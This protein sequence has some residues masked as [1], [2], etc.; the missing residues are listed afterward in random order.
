MYFAI[1]LI[2]FRLVK[3]LFRS[4]MKQHFSQGFR[5]AGILG[6]YLFTLLYEDDTTL[7]GLIRINLFLK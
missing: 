5:I 2:K 7:L 6:V 3:I 4:F 1:S